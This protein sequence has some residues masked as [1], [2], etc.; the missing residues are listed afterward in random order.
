[1]LTDWL[2]DLLVRHGAAPAVASGAT[3]LSYDGLLARVA[4]A[5]RRLETLGV[6]AGSTV[7]LDGPV[8]PAAIAVFLALVQRGDVIVP[9]GG[10]GGDARRARVEIA[11]ADFC[12]AVAADGET[13]LERLAP[14]AC[15]PLIAGLR[16]R[17]EGGLVLF[18][19]GS[20]G[21]VKAA[22]H[23]LPRLLERFRR[24]RAPLRTLLF[25]LFD[26]IGGLNTLLSVL[27]SGGCVVLADGRSPDDVAAT[28]ARQ[29]VECLPT[30]PTFLRM[31]LIARAH[32]QHD[33]SSLRLITYGTEVMPAP[34]LERLR[35]AFPEVRLKQTYG[36]T[37]TGILGTRS[38]AED[39][40]FLTIGG[41]G[42]ETRIVDGEL[43]VRAPTTMLGYLNAPSPIH[44]DGW[45]NTR[46]LV[47]VR[48]GRI[49]ILG[50]RAD[51]INVGGLKV[52]PV[53]VESVIAELPNVA[54]V[55]V[56]ARRNAV[57][58]QVV[59]ATVVLVAPEPADAF[60][61]RL[62]AHC[63][64]RGLDEHHI[65]AVVSFAGA[66]AATD[67]F[68]KARSRPWTT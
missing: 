65:P 66:T 34:T 11:G 43:W 42:I 48:D 30:T 14:A 6:P 18:T 61:A 45:L 16:T 3:T 7:A 25:L 17:G 38:E 5:A 35:A 64:A 68:K 26:H 63:R 59:T 54:D 21:E 62:W 40:V 10:V 4:A 44:A 15:P 2:F 27:S 55:T 47:E 39:G 32:D 20:T 67:R 31:L 23:A 50:R 28:I 58:G 57:L 1:V 51:V 22:C 8:G 19:S 12:V 33:L 29:R 9:L 52:N 36:L 49:R 24:P 53:E 46:D 13:T 37:E 41:D 60:E 56:A